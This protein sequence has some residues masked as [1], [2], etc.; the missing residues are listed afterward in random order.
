[1]ATN[2]YFQSG[3]PMGIRPESHLHE[4]LIIECLKIYGFDVYYLN[5]ESVN[6]DLIL[7]EDPLNKFTS[8]YQIEMYLE[9]V[10]GFGGDGALMS[11]FGLE[12]RDTATFLVSRR[13]WDLE[14]GRSGNAILTNRPSEG[15]LI[16]FPLTKSYFEIRK[17][18][19]TN[20]FFQ[21]GQLYVY[22]LECELYQYSSEEISTQDSTI[23]D[24]LGAYSINISDY[25]ILL[26]S[27]EKLLLEYETPSVVIREEYELK[28]IDKISDNENFETNISDILDFTERNPFG[29]VHNA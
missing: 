23:D 7:N 10:D 9:N 16:Y 21:V 27:G 13:R 29:E 17:V 2:H 12:I 8:A 18:V 22:R 25:E 5:R 19:A 28:D 14:I 4:D 3:I 24:T 6:E 1:M 26:E 15:D 20:P 11:K